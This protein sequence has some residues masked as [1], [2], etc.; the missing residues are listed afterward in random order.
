MQ[1]FDVGIYTPF[2]DNYPD[3]STCYTARTNAHIW[4]G[5]HAA[6]VNATHMSGQAPHVGLVVVKGAGLARRKQQLSTL[7]R[8]PVRDGTLGRKASL[9]PNPTFLPECVA[10]RTLPFSTEPFIP[11]E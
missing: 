5:E 3:A 1:L 7:K 8:H 2:N 6:Y 4:A 10:P 11:T 9:P